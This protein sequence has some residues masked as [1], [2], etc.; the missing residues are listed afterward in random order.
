[1]TCFIDRAIGQRI[2]R[3][4]SE[5]GLAAAAFARSIGVAPKELAE[6]ECGNARPTPLM[7][8]QIAQELGVTV[9]W[10][11]AEAAAGPVGQSK[12]ADQLSI[13]AADAGNNNSGPPMAVEGAI[14]Q[15]KDQ[16]G[17]AK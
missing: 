10:L 17:S 1:M 2:A 9:S 5:K 6:Y 12:T 14:S 7:L 3:C 16:S 4:R 8:F 11:F 13:G 15:H